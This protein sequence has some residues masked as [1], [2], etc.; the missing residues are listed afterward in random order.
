M[1]ALGDALVVVGVA[2]GIA[3]LAWW[4]VVSARRA[5]GSG[6]GV[7]DVAVEGGKVVVRPRG[8]WKLLALSGGLEIPLRHV[9]GCVV[10]PDPAL[11][12]PVTLRVGGTG[13]PG[14]I[15][16]GYMVGQGGR[17]WWA[18][19]FDGAAVVIELDGNALSYLVV[20]VDDP[21][22]TV[23]LVRSAMMR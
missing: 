5:G 18:Y 16:A 10:D 20:D 6:P 2:V 22:A 14:R 15:R 8:V 3:A 4:F 21:D 1:Q 13:L 23:R 7:A 11:S 9:S 12:L 19:R 17:S